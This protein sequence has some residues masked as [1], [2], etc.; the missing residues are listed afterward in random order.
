MAKPPFNSEVNYHD[1]V[2]TVEAPPL[3]VN[4]LSI[5]GLLIGIHSDHKFREGAS[6]HHS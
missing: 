3:H 4:E 5:F 6:F 2:I 1:D